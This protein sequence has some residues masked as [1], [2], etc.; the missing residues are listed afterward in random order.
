VGDVKNLQSLLIDLYGNKFAESMNREASGKG[1]RD[2]GYFKAYVMTV[3][4]QMSLLT[5]TALEGSLWQVTA[6]HGQSVFYSQVPK[7][8][9]STETTT[10]QAVLTLSE[11]EKATLKRSKFVEWFNKIKVK[12]W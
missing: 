7:G 10:P 11:D 3:E 5:N 6:V 9:S 12:I 4:N 1:S 2:W 8:I